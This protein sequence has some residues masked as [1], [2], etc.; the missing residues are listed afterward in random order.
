MREGVSEERRQLLKIKEVAD[1][2]IDTS[3]LTLSELKEM[4][5]SLLEVRRSNEMQLSFSSFG[6]KYGIPTD[7]DIVWDVR[8]LPNPNYVPPG[9]QAVPHRQRGAGAN[10][11]LCA[12]EN[13]LAQRFP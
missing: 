5:S 12:F 11:P 10:M 3:N 9:S 13:P 4:L 2:I 1:K 7:V 6:Y 8:F